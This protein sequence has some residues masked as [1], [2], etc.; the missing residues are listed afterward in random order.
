MTVDIKSHQENIEKIK[1]IIILYCFEEEI[2]NGKYNNLQYF[3]EQVRLTNKELLDEK[4]VRRH[5]TLGFVDC[6]LDTIA[7][8]TAGRIAKDQKLEEMWLSR[9]EMEHRGYLD[10]ATKNNREFVDMLLCEYRR[11]LENNYANLEDELFRSYE[12][13]EADYDDMNADKVVFDDGTPIYESKAYRRFLD[14]RKQ[15]LADYLGIDQDVLAD[16]IW[17]MFRTSY[18]IEPLSSYITVSYSLGGM[19]CLL[20]DAV[21][22]GHRGTG[23]WYQSVIKSEKISGVVEIPNYG[24]KPDINTLIDKYY[25]QMV[26]LHSTRN[27]GVELNRVE[28]V[29]HVKSESPR[30]DFIMITAMVS[31][32][33]LCKMFDLMQDHLFTTF[34]WEKYTGQNLQTR[35]ENM[36]ATSNAEREQQ[37]RV[38][39]ERIEKTQTERNRLQEELNGI[40]LSW[41]RRYEALE[42]E[43]K[44]KDEEIR[45]LKDRL[46][47][48]EAWIEDLQKEPEM[49]E[50]IPK[51]I[52]IP[53]GK[54]LFVGMDG[55]LVQD[56]KKAYPDSSFME[57]E[58]ADLSGLQVDAIVCLTRYMKHKMFYKIQAKAN[59]TIIYANGKTVEAVQVAMAEQLRKA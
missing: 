29:R 24:Y 10:R 15:E 32:D 45:A 6:V 4:K 17:E 53:D 54:Y 7:F 16:K 35:Y 44:E 14:K 20:V 26:K 22:A 13:I 36:L 40:E 56:L 37:H 43:S 34:S 42:K 38:L 21:L 31:M 55:R 23:D 19:F 50:K 39:E 57:S 33:I 41:Q 11:I 5:S 12:L 2:K 3:S 47:F 46:A 28:L 30:E 18:V 59:T 25:H 49:E 27:D 8:L 1:Q 51:E 52:W 48:Q 9:M 58:S